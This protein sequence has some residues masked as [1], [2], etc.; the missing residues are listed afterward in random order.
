[1]RRRSSVA[2]EIDEVDDGSEGGGGVVVVVGELWD[3]FFSFS[4]TRSSAFAGDLSVVVVV[5]VLPPSVPLLDEWP[6]V[7]IDV[8]ATVAAAGLAGADGKTTPGKVV[9]LDDGGSGDDMSPV[10]LSVDAEE[11]DSAA[12]D[13]DDG[14]RLSASERI[15]CY[16]V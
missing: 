16:I 11:E 9:V 14:D 6:L 12:D 15:I 5:A 3:D 4:L 2:I 7:T 10:I 13:E 1:M 8:V